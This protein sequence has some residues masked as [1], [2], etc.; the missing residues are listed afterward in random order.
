MSKDASSNSGEIPT[1]EAK[2]L[3]LDE[4]AKPVRKASN[5]TVGSEAAQTDSNSDK[6]KRK[7]IRKVR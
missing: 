3:E 1:E 6:K 5:T 4:E 7:G 2:D